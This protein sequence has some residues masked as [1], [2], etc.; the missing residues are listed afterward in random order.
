MERPPD[1][2]GRRGAVAII[3][4]DGRMLVIRRSRAVVAPLAACFPGGGIEPGESE[5]DALKRELREELGVETWP[6]RRLWQC[7]TAWKV[8][9]AWWLCGMADDAVVC[10]N[11]AEVDSVHWVT[12]A[13]MAAMSELLPSN[14]EF[15][16][17]IQ[18]G[19]VVL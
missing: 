14:K 18:C 10:P 13:E 16:D 11:P 19:E 12:P 2:P 9:L 1:D 3:V 5:T 8:E 17:L 7:V 6:L 4:R 15:L